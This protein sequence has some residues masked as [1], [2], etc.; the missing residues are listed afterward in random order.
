MPQ[1]FT[2]YLSAMS[3]MKCLPDEVRG[4]NF[5]DQYKN[6]ITFG[7]FSP[8][9]FYTK[10]LS[11]VAKYIMP[12]A[13]AFIKFIPVS[14]VPNT[15]AFLDGLLAFFSWV[16][17]PFKSIYWFVLRKCFNKE[18]AYEWSLIAD[19]THNHHSFSSFCCMLDTAKQNK[20]ENNPDSEK[21]LGFAMG[22]YAHVITDAIYHPMVYRSAKDHWN[23]KEFNPETLHKWLELQIDRWLANYTFRAEPDASKVP[24]Q[25]PGV[26]ETTLDSSIH[27]LLEACLLTHYR[28]AVSPGFQSADIDAAY[29]NYKYVA[30]LA[31]SG[32]YVTHWGRGAIVYG[33]GITPNSGGDYFLQ[34]YRLKLE[35]GNDVFDAS[36]LDL[37][38]IAK[39]C[40]VQTFE[41]VFLFW[42]SVA[43][44]SR[45]FFQEHYPQLRYLHE[46]WNLDTGLPAYL[47]EKS[48]IQDGRGELHYNAF[49]DVLMENY[50]RFASIP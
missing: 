31:Y 38:N 33:E 20:L 16:M 12:R 3:A 37:A 49:V 7:T 32:K 28:G 11:P 36:V 29:A 43:S 24:W 23:S 2:H 34:K 47:N 40:L 18:K 46:N 35:S 1:P 17:T 30:G 4:R 9:L 39:S 48:V 22:F 25:C 8:D 42:D 19:R 50:R 6:F 21:Q 14:W 15:F 44:D 5:W 10:N 27:Q 26:Q 41:A 13:P 45:P